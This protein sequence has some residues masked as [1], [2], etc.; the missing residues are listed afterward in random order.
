MEEYI[1]RL[2]YGD[3]FKGYLFAITTFTISLNRIY[4]TDGSVQNGIFFWH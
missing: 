4:K 1:K 2:F 3:L